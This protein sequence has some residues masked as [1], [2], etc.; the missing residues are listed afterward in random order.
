MIEVHDKKHSNLL[1]KDRIEGLA[2]GIFA[3]AMTLLVLNLAIPEQ[4]QITDTGLLTILVSQGHRFFNYALAFILLGILWIVHHQQFNNIPKVNSRLIWINIFILM[5]IA[6]MPF[7]SDLIGDYAETKVAEIFFC[8]N[9]FII[10]TLYSFNWLYASKNRLIT[11]DMDTD[12]I[13]RG[14]RRNLVTPVV[15]LLAILLTLILPSWSLLTFLLVPIILS[16]KP[17]HR[18][19]RE[20][21]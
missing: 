1:S 8:L 19:E 14:E 20:H 17:F 9:L 10:G 11:P 18:S 21:S 5:F 15:S 7:S 4:A 3:F 13:R 16:T 6:L 12:S 2:D